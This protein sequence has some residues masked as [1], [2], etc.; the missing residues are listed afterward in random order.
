MQRDTRPNGY[1]RACCT[2]C[3]AWPGRRCALFWGGGLVPVIAREL[4]PCLDLVHFLGL[5]LRPTAARAPASD[6]VTWSAAMWSGSRAAPAWAA[7]MVEGDASGLG[8]A[9]APHPQASPSWSACSADAATAA[10]AT[11]AGMAGAPLPQASFN[12]TAGCGD[13]DTGAASGPRRAGPGL[14]QVS[15]SSAECCEDGDVGVA[16]GPGM[17]GA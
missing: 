3:C 5:P 7:G 10:A 6:P 2:P 8:M 13:G 9:G 16:S 4:L 15:P 1:S 12:S 11:G 14:P 17:A